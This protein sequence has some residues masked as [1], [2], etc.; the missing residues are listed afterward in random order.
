MMA[1]DKPLKDSNFDAFCEKIVKSIKISE[2]LKKK[3]NQ[4]IG[5]LLIE[6]IQNDLEIFSPAYEL[7]E[8]V[9]QRLEFDFQKYY[10]EENEKAKNCEYPNN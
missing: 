8:S 2:A 9:L 4:E 3:T 6:Y 7:I 1:E 10:D 5:L